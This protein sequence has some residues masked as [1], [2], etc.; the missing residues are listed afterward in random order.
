MAPGN[1]FSSALTSAPPCAAEQ[2]RPTEG[3]GNRQAVQT[4]SKGKFRGMRIPLRP[5]A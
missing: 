3:M 5:G 1:L 4:D 2:C